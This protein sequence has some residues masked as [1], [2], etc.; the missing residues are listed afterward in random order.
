MENKEVKRK[1]KKRKIKLT[2][3]GKEVVGGIITLSLL[4]GATTVLASSLDKP[5][6]VEPV[7]TTIVSEYDDIFETEAN[8]APIINETTSVTPTPVEETT[9]SETI[10]TPTQTEEEIETIVPTEE[11]EM[12]E[13]TNP[14]VTEV[15][16]NT[17]NIENLSG[18]STLHIGYADDRNQASDLERYTMVR[19][20]YGALI[21]YVSVQT[22][23]DSRL[24]TALISQENPDK[25][26][27][28]RNG[29]YGLTSINNINQGRTNPIRIN[30]VVQQLTVDVYSLNDNTLFMDGLY[31][32]VTVGDYRAILTEI[33]IHSYDFTQ[34]TNR[35][36]P[37]DAAFL[38][39]GSYNGGL[40]TI[41]GSDANA[42]LN[43]FTTNLY[44]SHDEEYYSHVLGK[45]TA[46]YGDDMTNQDPIVI[47]DL[48]GNSYGFYID[49]NYDSINTVSVSYDL[50]NSH[51]L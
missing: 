2:K 5:D 10:V 31:G 43:N 22:G 40:G 39:L 27:Q 21:D 3:L 6:T 23:W 11:I 32:D 1:I 37:T 8:L 16:E 33:S 51:T 41:S 50:A 13:E 4:G 9:S 19:E 48:D 15:I 36:S 34:L 12:I 49:A 25:D 44:Y 30:G 24:I 38:C 14:E 35:Y 46:Y 45:I 26:D 18:V 42:A 20:R 17:S 28:S 29:T 7:E 47:T